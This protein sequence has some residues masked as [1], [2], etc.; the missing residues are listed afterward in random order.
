M[1]MIVSGSR[2]VE[3][4]ETLGALA[5]RSSEAE[6]SIVGAL[7]EGLEGARSVTFASGARSRL[8]QALGE[9]PGSAAP[10]LLRRLA[11]D[12]DPAVAR[13]ATYLVGL[14]GAGNIEEPG[15]KRSGTEKPD[16]PPRD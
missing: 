4:A 5:A 12:P 15:G 2:D 10:A 14:R 13:V 9:I 6:R 1:A 3:A 7:A 16:A 8:A 11:G